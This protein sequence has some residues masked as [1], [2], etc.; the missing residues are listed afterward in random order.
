MVKKLNK[1]M[2][3]LI[4]V[5][6]LITGGSIASIFILRSDT[7]SATLPNEGEAS[8]MTEEQYKLLH[9]SILPIEFEQMSQTER[10]NAWLFLSTMAEMNFVENRAPG[11]SGVS[12]ATWILDLLGVGE[13]SEF[14]VVDE[15]EDDGGYNV[16]A[17]FTARITNQEGEI[18]YI[19]Y[20]QTQGLGFVNK[21]SVDGELLYSPVFHAIV[22]GQIF[23]REY[24]RGPA[25][26]PD[27]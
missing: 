10:R 19:R 11:E 20:F 14:V 5:C 27:Q 26:I 9:E 13:I 1:K 8:T 2:I 21:G 18:Y 12:L 7:H 6:A 4:V 17:W 25:I 3:V 23:E 22:D 16:N 15:V 24:P